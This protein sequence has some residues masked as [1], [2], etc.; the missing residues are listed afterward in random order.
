MHSVDEGKAVDE[1]YIDISMASDTVSHSILLE[2]LAARVLDSCT[3][4]W[5]KKC[6]AQRV[7]VNGVESSWQLVTSGLPQGSGSG[8]VLFN[9]FISDLDEGIECTLSKFADGTR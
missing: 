9:I 8:P 4:R 6:W 5:V 7:I 3:V 2:K 1:V